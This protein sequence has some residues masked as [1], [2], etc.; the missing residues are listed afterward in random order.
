MICPSWH[1]AGARGDVIKL[2]HKRI[3]TILEFYCEIQ[4]KLSD[5]LSLIAR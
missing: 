1:D 3:M 4:C 5:H 2:A